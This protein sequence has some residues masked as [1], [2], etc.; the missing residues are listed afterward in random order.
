MTGIEI[1]LDALS[2]RGA[3]LSEGRPARPKS[4]IGKNTIDA[5]RLAS[6]VYAGAIR[7]EIMRRCTTI[8]ASAAQAMRQSAVP[9]V[10]P[11]TRRSTRSTTC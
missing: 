8:S 5:I 1:S 9:A 10:V 3:R 2:E 4:V 7:R 11:T 6:F